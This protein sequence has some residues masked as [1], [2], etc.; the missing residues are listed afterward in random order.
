MVYQNV[1]LLFCETEET[2][3]S[4]Y[5]VMKDI[6]EWAKKSIPKASWRGNLKHMHNELAEVEV[7]L[8]KMEKDGISPELHK[9]IAHELA[10]LVILA[11]HMAA[12]LNIELSQAV[13]DKMA[14]NKKRTWSAP[15]ENGVIHHV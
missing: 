6:G 12:L 15:D 7:E 13:V 10:D 5:E 8:L 11:G 9:D 3:P 4:F 2:K 1:K 14:I